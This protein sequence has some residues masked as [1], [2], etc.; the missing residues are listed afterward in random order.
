MAV[1]WKAGR[2]TQPSNNRAA[3]ADGG[4]AL[5]MAAYLEW[6]RYKQ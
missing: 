4:G 5:R 1:L 6:A 2:D 3:A